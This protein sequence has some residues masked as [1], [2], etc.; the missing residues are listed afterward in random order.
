MATPQVEQAVD[1]GQTLTR[2]DGDAFRQL[3]AFWATG[4]SVL[5]ACGDDGPAGATAN[6]LTSLSLEPPLALV[7][8]DLSSRT[9]KAVRESERFCINM[10]GSHQEDVSRI[11]A[12]K[13]SPSGKFAEIEYRMEDGVPVIEGC[14]AHLVCSLDSELRRGDHVVVIGDVLTG[15]TDSNGR[16]LIFYRGQYQAVR[17]PSHI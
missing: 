7:C 4:V 2:L 15:T 14:L 8:F 6:A 17:E 11:F 9:L 16:P 12:S 13:R 5:T 3:M 10:L 1:P